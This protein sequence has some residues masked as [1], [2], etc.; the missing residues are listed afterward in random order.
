MLMYLHLS[1][2]TSRQIYL[3]TCVRLSVFFQFRYCQCIFYT[4]PFYIIRWKI[5]TNFKVLFSLH[6]IKSLTETI[7]D[8]SA[9]KMPKEK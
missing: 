1:S 8:I 7:P 9:I 4:F 3:L 6:K 2:F 5:S